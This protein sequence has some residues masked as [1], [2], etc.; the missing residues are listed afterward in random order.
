MQ[1]LEI[2]LRNLLCLLGHSNDLRVPFLDRSSHI[3]KLCHRDHSWPDF[4]HVLRFNLC[5]SKQSIQR[6]K[7][8]VQISP[9]SKAAQKEE[10]ER[11]G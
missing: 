8:A 6:I 1:T 10:K 5:D 3:C 7:V 2:A 9:T 4:S 11:A